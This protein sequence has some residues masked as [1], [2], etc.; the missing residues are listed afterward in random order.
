MSDT[1]KKE[2]FQHPVTR[3]VVITMLA[4]WAI[5]LGI[6]ITINYFRAQEL[7]ELKHDADKLLIGQDELKYRV[8]TVQRTLDKK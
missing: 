7:Q 5:I 1:E 4:L 3:A 6:V 2:P 8:E